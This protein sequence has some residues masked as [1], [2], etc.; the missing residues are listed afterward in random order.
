MASSFHPS[1]LLPRSIR[2]SNNMIVSPESDVLHA[3]VSPRRKN[4]GEAISNGV[5]R[6]LSRRGSLEKK[7]KKKKE[8]KKNKKKKRSSYYGNVDVVLAQPPEQAPLEFYTPK[9]RKSPVLLWLERGCPHDVV[10]KILAFCGPKT[11][12]TLYQ[13]NRF[14]Y[15]LIGSDNTWRVMCEE[16]Y[17]W[18]EGDEEPSCSWR[19]F[20]TQNPCVPTDYSNLADAVAAI[21]PSRNE[22]LDDDDDMDDDLSYNG[23]RLDLPT[24]TIWLRP[25]EHRLQES[26]LLDTRHANVTLETMRT[27]TKK[28]QRPLASLLLQTR[29]RNKPLIH[30]AAGHVTLRKLRLGHYCGGFNLWN[31]N[32]AVQIQPIVPPPPA[33]NLLLEPEQPTA[34][35]SATLQEV[36]VISHSGRGVVIND[37]GNV[38]IAKSYIHDCAATGI[39]VGSHDCDLTLEYSDLIANGHGNQLAASVRASGVSRGH[40]GFYLENGNASLRQV[41]ISNNSS[42]GISVSS[43]E[44]KLLLDHS[45]VV[46]N[47]HANQVEVAFGSQQMGSSN[48]VAKTGLVKVRSRLGLQSCCG[49]GMGNGSRRN[50][51]S[52]NNSSN[53]EFS[54]RDYGESSSDED[55]VGEEDDDFEHLQD[56]FVVAEE[57]VR[58]GELIEI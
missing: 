38:T 2:P 55:E 47:G 32:A 20:Y 46:A 35:P 43:S 27:T 40:S 30:I 6:R 41:N 54:E 17:K 39:Y 22:I 8:S 12:A 36:E 3:P 21:C 45:D 23:K 18:K 58:F 51:N 52:N 5:I 15:D 7:N 31:G 11:T 24:R 48:N 1:Q 28:K 42:C 29:R 53:S 25:Q 34:L 9:P 33:N 44:S 14:W 16:L 50:N 13:C 10:P 26:L 37:G 49:R 19:E 56:S 57:N 4:M